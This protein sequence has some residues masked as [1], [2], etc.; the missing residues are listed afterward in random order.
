[1]L[2]DASEVSARTDFYAE[3]A[4]DLIASGRIP[5]D[6]VIFRAG[7]LP[8][9]VNGYFILNE[10]YKKWR[11]SDTH[12]TQHEKIAALTCLSIST[13]KPFRPLDFG[14]VRTFAQDRANEMFALACASMII[15]A[16]LRFGTGRKSNLMYRIM[17]IIEASE[18]VTLEPYIQDLNLDIRKR[19]DEYDLD[20]KEEDK[21]AINSLISIFEL[22]PQESRLRKDA[23]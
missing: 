18:C 10:A 23:Q 8:I 13:F 12:R 9:L 20:I 15:G 11:I 17:D 4:E 7:R 3:I 22:I 5:L 21:L 14:D 16:D 2:V 19:I 6:E 1:V